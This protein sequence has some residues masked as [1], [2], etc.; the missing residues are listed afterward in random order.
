[1][2]RMVA[3]WPAA[4]IAKPSWMRVGSI[5]DATGG[6]DVAVNGSDGQR[7]ETLLEWQGGHLCPVRMDEDIDLQAHAEV[8]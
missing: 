8:G 4:Y 3:P 5:V 6:V 7:D 1:M 2:K